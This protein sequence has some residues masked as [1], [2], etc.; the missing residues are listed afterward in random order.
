MRLALRLAARGR[1]RVSPNP[2]VGAVVAR[3]GSI[4]AKGYHR[5]FGG[6]HAE[7][8]ALRRAGRRAR[9]ADL[10][11]TLEPC[12][13]QGKT[14][15]CTDAILRAGVA[16]VIFA[17]TDPNPVTHGRGPKI[18][19]QSG[20]TVVEGLLA[21]AARGQNLP[22]FHWRA[23]GRPWVIIK[24]AMTLDGKIATRTGESRWITGQKA[25]ERAHQLRRRADGVLAGTETFRR[26]DPLLLPR[27][28]RG[29]I[30]ARVVLDRRGRLPWS[31][32][33]LSPSSPESGRRI[34]VVSPRCP[35]RR[36]LEVQR[37]GLEVI[38]APEVHGRLSLPAVLDAL[39]RAGIC[40][41]L[42]EGGGKLIGDLV[43][44]R[45]AQEAA[46]FVA[47]VI[48]GGQEAPG[49]AADRGIGRI[50]EALELESPVIRR[51]GRDV[52]IEGRI[53]I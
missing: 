53:R 6:A 33:A 29:R 9:G 44:R 40:Q 8:E 34:Y 10:Y 16:R 36:R 26:D 50:A 24:W 11:V 49:P 46:V 52:M 37:R 38:E 17:A 23:T 14:P 45:L 2:M 51:L 7:V 12:A 41:L 42:V 28:S 27:P 18:L 30:P 48:F 22:Y 21:G 1:D 47:P 25:R 13:H 3:G 19:R 35:R 4:V 20:V 15:P 43:T 39:G 32:K 31:L 5:R